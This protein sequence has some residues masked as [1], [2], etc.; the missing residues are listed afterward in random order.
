VARSSEPLF[1]SF[2]NSLT[3]EL[4]SSQN[5][6]PLSPP[7]TL[8][9][10]LTKEENNLYFKGVTPY[11]P[12]CPSQNV[13][14]PS[15]LDTTSNKV[16]STPTAYPNNKKIFPLFKFRNYGGK[17]IKEVSGKQKYYKYIQKKCSVKYTLTEIDSSGSFTQVRTFSS[18]SHNH[19]PPPNPHINPDVKKQSL[20]CLRAGA[21]PV[22]I[23]K[24]QVRE[25][26]LSLS[27]TDVPT[28]RMFHKWKHRGT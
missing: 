24:Q 26:S 28:M 17:S 22:N 13:Q 3:T 16:P 25:A 2:G 12:L 18:E 23:H 14:N 9:E 11:D 21:S 15:T 5:L 1:S 6:Q 20:A 4:G 7:K 10:Y 27:S 19:P 8:K